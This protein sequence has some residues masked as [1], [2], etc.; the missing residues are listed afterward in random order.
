MLTYTIIE[1]PEELNILA[2]KQ[3]ENF[4]QVEVIMLSSGVTCEGAMLSIPTSDD[5]SKLKVDL[6][7]LNTRGVYDCVGPSEPAHD[8]P[9]R[10]KRFVTTRNYY[11]WLWTLLGLLKLTTVKKKLY[12]LF[13]YHNFF[14]FNFSSE[15]W[16]LKK[17]FSK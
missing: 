5:I 9:E 14:K 15:D 16:L 2:S 7:D 1:S 6:N 8:D 3:Q 11:V 4:I 13:I 12:F 10:E 17:Y